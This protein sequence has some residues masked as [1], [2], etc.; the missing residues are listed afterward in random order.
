MLSWQKV[1]KIAQWQLHLSIRLPMF[2]FGSH[3]LKLRRICKCRS[4]HNLLLRNQSRHY[5]TQERLWILVTCLSI[6]HLF[7]EHRQALCK[8]SFSLSL[9]LL[10]TQKLIMKTKLIIMSLSIIRE[11]Q[12]LEMQC[13]RWV[14]LRTHHME[15]NINL[16]QSMILGKVGSLKCWNSKRP[17]NSSIKSQTN[18]CKIRA[19][20]HLLRDLAQTAEK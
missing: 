13:A 20:H 17:Q 3:S 16:P 9:K 8:R 7:R 12:N 10:S 1:E 19:W 4:K 14:L 15:R 18:C 6:T 5:V 11:H 2:S